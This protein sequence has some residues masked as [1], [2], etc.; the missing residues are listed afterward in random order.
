MQDLCRHGWQDKAY[1]YVLDETSGTREQRA[2]EAY[3]RALHRASAK[4][5]FHCRMLLTDDPRPRS[6]GGVKTANSFLFNDVDIWATRYYFFFGR[7]PV[8][9]QL[10]AKGKQVWWYF[11]ANHFVGV[12][13]SFVI[14]KPHSGQ[15]VIPWLMQQWHVQ[16]MLNWGINR[17]TDATTERGWRDPYRDPLSFHKDRIWS[18]GDTCLIY[19]GYYP[20]YGLKDPYAQ[21]VSSLRLEALRDGFQDQ[22]YLQ[23]AEQTGA[24]SAAFVAG[25]IK[26]ITWYPFAVRYGNS[27]TSPSTPTA[28]PASPRRAPSWRSASRPTRAAEARTDA[29]NAAATPNAA[30]DAD[31]APGAAID[32]PPWTT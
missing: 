31:S 6:L 10:Q 25:V 2:A 13:P 9:R 23:L 7:E 3:A 27:S 19:P 30:P 21:P 22:Q 20:R 24:G 11:Y 16:G 5:G 29:H 1:A 28:P 4:A 8:L 32:C 15:R 14:E 17:W 18:N 26:T 12:T